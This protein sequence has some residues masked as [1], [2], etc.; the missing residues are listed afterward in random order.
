[1][2]KMLANFGNTSLSRS[3]MKSISGGLCQVCSSGTNGGTCGSASFTQSEAQSMVNDFN[4]L[5]DGY[6]YFRTCNE[7]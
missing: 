1:M 2:K 5:N 4:T 7:Q 3:E 6:I